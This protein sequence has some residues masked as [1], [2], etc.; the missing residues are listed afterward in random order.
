MKALER[1]LIY[2]VLA[3]LVLYVFLVNDN[4]ESKIAIQEEIRARSIVIVDDEGQEAI[5]LCANKNGGAISIYNKAGKDP[6]N[7]S[8]DDNGYGMIVIYDIKG[9]HVY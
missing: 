6:I 5:K 4:V 8:I 9:F 7:I 3:I 1:I 2:S